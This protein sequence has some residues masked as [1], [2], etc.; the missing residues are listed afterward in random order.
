MRRYVMNHHS[1]THVRRLAV[2]S[3]I[4]L[5]TVSVLAGTVYAVT[6]GKT[7]IA[8]VSPG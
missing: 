8:A 4:L 5:L 7:S 2:V 1:F 6:L 3:V